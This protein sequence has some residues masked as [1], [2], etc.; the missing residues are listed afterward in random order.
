MKGGGRA[1]GKVPH[2]YRKGLPK[3]MRRAAL[4][5]AILAKMLGA[6]LMVIDG[7][8]PEQPKTK[9]VT[10]VLKSLKIER[11]CLLTLAAHNPTLW[12]SARNIASLAV[13]TAGDLN[14]FDVA[15]RQTMLVTREAMTQL[16]QERA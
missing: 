11:S 5:S 15:T 7:L 9:I 16:L 6:D 10:G 14:A 3:N 12:K 2:S 4:D 8:A 1:F 13:C